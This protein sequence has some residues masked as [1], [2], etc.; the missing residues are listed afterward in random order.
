MSENNTSRIIL[1]KTTSAAPDDLDLQ[2]RSGGLDASDLE[3]RRWPFSLRPEAITAIDI[4]K[5]QGQINV[6]V[7]QINQVV[8]DAPTPANGFRLAEFEVSA[9][10]KAEAEGEIQLVLLGSAKAIGGVSAGL[11]F[12]FRRS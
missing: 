8:N 4:T 1:V 7:Q 3:P 6:F 5:L 10:I 2:P 9:E 12:V 11:K